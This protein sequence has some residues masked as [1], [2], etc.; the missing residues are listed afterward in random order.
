MK[1]MKRLLCMALALLT[2]VVSMPFTAAQVSAAPASTV[3]YYMLDN[4]VLDAMEYLGYDVSA[5]KS[6]GTIFVEAGYDYAAE[7][8][9]VNPGSRG[10]DVVSS[11]ST[12]TGY[13]PNVSKFYSYGMCCGSFITYYYLNY[14][15][16][17]AGENMTAIIDAAE[18]FHDY[19]GY[20]YQAVVF[21]DYFLQEQVDAGNA[22]QLH[23]ASASDDEAT[24]PASTYN[25]MLPGDLI[26]FGNSSNEW[27][28]CAIYIG[29]H[30]G[31]HWIAHMVSEGAVIG[32][33]EGM[34]YGTG[35]KVSHPTAVYRLNSVPY[36][37][38]FGT[39]EVYKEDPNGAALAGAKFSATHQE[40]GRVFVIG[41]TN[42]NGYAATAKELP[43]GTYTVVETVFPEGYR[44][45][46]GSTNEWTVTLSQDSQT[47]TVN[48]INDPYP[49]KLTISKSTSDGKNLT[50]WNFTVTNASTG[51]KVGDY[52][53]TSGNSVYVGEL[54]PGTYTITE[55]ISSSSAYSAEKKTQTV[56]IGVDE[57]VTVNFHNVLKPG[58]LTFK[59]TTEDGSNLSGWQF[60]LYTDAACTNL[61]YGPV[62]TDS[63]GNGRFDNVIVGDYY[64]KELG[65]PTASINDRYA[66][67]STNPQKVTIKANE[68][69]TGPTFANNIVRGGIRI[70]KTTNTGRDLSGWQFQIF[71]AAGSVV[72]TVTTNDYGV[73]TAT[74]LLPGTYTVKEVQSHT[75]MWTYDSQ[76]KSV[77]VVSGVNDTPVSFHNV[78]YG[79]IQ[80]TKTTNT[81]NDLSGWTFELYNSA[82][83]KIDTKTT[84]ADGKVLFDKLEPG[85]YT[86][87]ETQGRS[88]M[89]IMDTDTET[90]QVEVN[91]TKSVTFY[92][93]NYGQI[94][95]VKSTNTGANLDGWT[96]ELYNSAG[97]LVASKTTGADGKVLFD[98]LVPGTYTVKEKQSHSGMWIMDTDTETVQVEVNTKK[99]VSFYNTNYGQ[100][101]VVKSTN[102][103]NDLYGWT[104][105]LYNSAGA[106]V[107]TKTTGADG[108]ALFDK[109][110]PGTYTVKEVRNRDGMWIYDSTD[111][112]VTVTANN[113]ATAS[114]RNVNY[115]QI[116]VTKTTNTG[117][118]LSG[119]TFE[120]YNSAGAKVD[121]K[122]T[123]ANGKVLFDQLEPGTYTIKEVQSHSGM[124]IMDTHTETVT[125]KVNE[126]AKAS[127]HNVNYGQIQVRKT[128]NTGANLSGWTFELYDTSGKLV[129]TKVTNEQGVA[130]FDQ[131][132]PGNYTV[133]EKQDVAGM[134]TYDT[135]VKSVTVTVNTTATPSAFYNVNYGQV[136]VVKSTNTGNDLSGWTFELYDAAGTKV[137]TKTTGADG[138]ALFDKLL[139]GTYTVKEVR[140]RDGM[141]IYDSTDKTVTVTA[142]SKATAS[143]RNVN[144]GQI[145]VTKTTNTGNDLSGWTFELYDASGS[146]VDTQTTGANGKVLFDKLLPGTYTVKE[147]QE[148]AGMWI[149]DTDVETVTVKV[150]ETATAEFHNINYGRIRVNKTTNTG[151]DLDGWNFELYDSTGKLVDTQATNGNGI[152]VFDKLLPGTYTV[153]EVQNYAGMWIFDTDV[154][155]VEVAANEVSSASFHNLHYGQIQVTKETNTGANLSGWTFELYD[156]AGE[157]V[158]TQTT[159][160][161]GKALFDKV[162]PGTYT[163]KELHNRSGMW[164][165]DTQD[166]AVTVEVEQVAPVSYYNIN[167]GQLQVVK[168]IADNGAGAD[169]GWTFK[170]WKVNG[171]DRNDETQWEFISEGTTVKDANDPSYTWTN[172]L[173][174]LYVIQEQTVRETHQSDTAYHFVTVSVDTTY[175]HTVTNIEY[176]IAKVKKTTNTGVDLENWIVDI[177]KDAEC[178]DLVISLTTDANG[179]AWTYLLPGTYY[180]RE[181]ANTDPYW[182]SD[183]EVKTLTVAPGG[184]YTVDFLNNHMGKIMVT[185]TMD[186]D[187][188]V[189]G[190]QFVIKDKD[191]NEIE[192]SP[193]VTVEKEIEDGKIVGY[194]ETGLL[195]PGE[196]TIEEIFPEGSLYYCK[197]ENP[198]KVT[199]TA[200]A[201]TEA[202]FI[203]ALRPGEI[204]IDK[205]NWAGEK[206][207]GA[208]FL[209][210]WSEN[211][212]DWY[213]VVYSDA[214]D[215]VKGGCSNPNLVDGHLTTG[216]DGKLVFGN[217]YPGLQYRLTE[218]EAPNGY[219][220][221]ADYA[222][223]GTL[224]VDDLAEHITVYNSKGYILPTT[225]STRFDFVSGGLVM[226]VLAA[227]ALSMMLAQPAKSVIPAEATGDDK[228]NK[229][230]KG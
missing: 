174:G 40:S 45:P 132:L 113:K 185:K 114:F 192:G 160:A 43:M 189:A 88:G 106:K 39:I 144:Y 4:Y 24:I 167:Y 150:N 120:L 168:A 87:K 108:K 52:T 20:S 85:T 77:T 198:L 75:G 1:T 8:P 3:P 101:E 187:G 188:P 181:Q 130:L 62:S 116:E 98:Q 76:S 36:R 200:G 58:S 90:V 146:L 49:G 57:S 201:D 18:E 128:T 209:L 137:D 155:T 23:Y 30:G 81:G 105:E 12:A 191:G 99:S 83:T 86:V 14:L 226:A 227:V 115:G 139:P 64:L 82:G 44:T 122:T 56:T 156:A 135:S 119:W 177:F 124:W 142:G 55:N 172:L 148:H 34:A 149:F 175:S 152:A 25:S 207:A 67:V 7:I 219:V 27:V 41:P 220:L 92:N 194:F 215:V 134:W 218:T 190:W 225:P 97:S 153:K 84:G 80:V 221:L 47:I 29:S 126:T 17:I 50:G 206:L 70:T 228:N 141:W 28:H 102:T 164:I 145:E 157:L 118:D 180:F 89:W 159:G 59:K 230:K 138:K 211:G 163:V 53:I 33:V 61:A 65:H 71:D 103:G 229:T 204:T 143:F 213:P 110:L 223:L 171:A 11:S 63:S 9:Y 74:N 208:T 10:D 72:A 166:K 100:I 161:D 125:V 184:E 46:P 151:E 197:T 170:L 2:M 133:K 48:A 131:V 37:E 162:L 22:I 121:S 224:P 15:P 186:T 104:F 173:P 21:W 136:E 129:D 199:V 111:K 94:E 165:Y 16:N 112:T 32:T 217:L 91:T 96:F 178:T 6:N 140:N 95:V 69:V 182:I 79:Q 210:E 68:T 107:D 5:D 31:K 123:G 38:S 35:S 117:N 26:I 195:Q 19:T 109:L 73:A 222:Y 179:E 183:V 60:A 66:C 93:V 154:E 147:K 51:A 54:P 13:A 196:Y 193:F 202:H 214:P 127:F 176:G 212:T 42:S 158:D 216:E 78:N 205:V 203:N 169:L